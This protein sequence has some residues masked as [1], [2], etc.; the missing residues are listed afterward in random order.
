MIKSLRE[1]RL[2]DGLPRVVAGLDWVSSLS[3]A[4]GI[5]HEQTVDFA[6]ESQI[7]TAIDS[8]SED[9]LD[10]LAV[11]WKV[12]WYDTDYSVEQKRRIIKTAL[13]ARRKMGTVGAVRSQAE[14]IY[15]NTTIKEWFDYGGKPGYFRIGFD[16]RAVT[17]SDVD[18][19]VNA[20][21]TVKRLSVWID[22]FE[23]DYTTEPFHE[24]QPVSALHRFAQ[25]L[26]M[27]SLWRALPI[28]KPTLTHWTGFTVAAT[29]PRV[30][31]TVGARLTR[32]S[33]YSFDGSACF[34][35]VRRFDA[36]IKQEEI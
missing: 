13:T 36:S 6:D 25:R 30:N 14:A 10:A 1:A 27:S 8:V 5:T 18:R 32:D 24:Q 11:N 4:V 16:A 33:M 9:V 15:P 2:K 31:E 23:W 22:G 3:Q 19:V 17:M 26:A 28:Q 35:G 20:V 29:L 21:N 12:D 7:Y 34:N